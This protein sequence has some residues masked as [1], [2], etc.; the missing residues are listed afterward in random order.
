[1]HVHAALVAATHGKGLVPLVGQRRHKVI[2]GEEI[3][4]QTRDEGVCGH[5]LP[6]PDHLQAGLLAFAND[7]AIP[8][9]A[10]VDRRVDGV[11]AYRDALSKLNKDWLHLFLREL[12]PGSLLQLVIETLDCHLVKKSLVFV[13][14]YLLFDRINI[15]PKAVPQPRLREPEL[16]QTLQKLKALLRTVL[17]PALLRKLGAHALYQ[18]RQAA[19]TVVKSVVEQEK[20][21]AHNL[22]AVH[23]HGE[24]GLSGNPLHSHPGRR[25]QTAACRHAQSRAK[26]IG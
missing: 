11:L 6:R 3:N 12:M 22:L 14:S 17:G 24:R 16:L 15:L 21:A 23:M 26:L 1:M 7:G 4:E 13:L 18:L 2:R 5:V 20:A 8:E 10:I 19:V 9:N 25:V